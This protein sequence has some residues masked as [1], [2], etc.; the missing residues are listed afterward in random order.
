MP[1]Q[2][3]VQTCAR[4]LPEFRHVEPATFFL[5]ADFSRNDRWMAGEAMRQ[6]L[7]GLKIVNKVRC[8]GIRQ[9]RRRSDVG[10]LRLVATRSQLN[11]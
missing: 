6:H 9:T 10:S 7:L 4:W 1:E 8:A 3:P 5:R 2:E 11:H